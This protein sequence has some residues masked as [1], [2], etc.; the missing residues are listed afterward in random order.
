MMRGTF[1]S[2][3]SLVKFTNTVDFFKID[4]VNF[5]LI[6]E[7]QALLYPKADGRF[8]TTNSPIAQLWSS[9][10][11]SQTW[12]RHAVSGLEVVTGDCSRTAQMGIRTLVAPAARRR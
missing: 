11:K 7:S 2:T 12:P 10:M 4:P 3:A 5:Q 9:I 1:C 8:W 6:V